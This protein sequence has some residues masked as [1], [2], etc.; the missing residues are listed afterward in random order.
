MVDKKEDKPQDP[1]GDAIDVMRAAIRNAIFK[2]MDA[3]Y[4][5]EV[6]LSKAIGNSGNDRNTQVTALGCARAYLNDIVR[7]LEHIG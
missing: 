3:K 5:A 6:E 2:A 7:Q 4:I 1:L